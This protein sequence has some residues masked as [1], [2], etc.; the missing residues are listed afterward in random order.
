MELRHLRYL[1]AV[2]DEGSVTRAAARLGIQQPPLSQQIQAL[3]TELGIAL[4]VRHPKGVA[5]TPGGAALL[6]EARAIIARVE[7]ASVRAVR[8]ADG[9][10]GSLTIGLTSSVVAHRLAPDIIRAHREAFPAVTLEVREGNAADLTAAVT[11]GDI[12]VAF[13]R[14]PVARPAELA[15]RSLLEE[16]M[17]LVLPH[18]HRAAG[19]ARA[20]RA[21]R[22]KTLAD[23]P[24]ILVR[25]PGAPGMYANLI[26]ACHRLGFAPRIATEV[27]HMGTNIMLVAAGVGVSVVPASMRDT[28]RDLVTYHRLAD[29]PELVAPLTL[30]HRRDSPNPVIAPFLTLCA[31]LARKRA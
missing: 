10:E 18:G 26:T 30:A 5:P 31:S 22:L 28:H 2:A 16:P 29:A 15:Y 13:V 20:A 27:S 19:A 1:I 4:F 9:S 24:F 6:D 11:A 8:V 23:E 7:R 25:R 14:E 21:V 3:E 17:L 12:D